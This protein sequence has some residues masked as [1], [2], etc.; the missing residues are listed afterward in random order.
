MRHQSARPES[1][2]EV[3]AELSAKQAQV[4]L[5]WLIARPAVTA[6][7]ASA[8]SIRQFEHTLCPARLAFFPE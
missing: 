7:I 1:L 2:D 6:L 3:A 5:A 4:A 8:T